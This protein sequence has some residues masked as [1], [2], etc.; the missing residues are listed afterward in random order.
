MLDGE[1]SMTE[2]K[3]IKNRYEPLIK[4]IKE[5]INNSAP[6]ESNYKLYLDFGFNLLEN[7]DQFYNSANP[8]IKLQTLSS[9]YAEKFFFEENSDRTP[10]YREELALI[11][12]TD[13]AFSGK[14]GG[15][16]QENLILSSEVAPKVEDSNFILD[17]LKEFSDT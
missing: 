11:L 8:T 7:V 5:E 17:S 16:N 13:K 12:N 9:M 4:Q 10:T 2:Y 15:Q 1:L 6:K 3:A 14:K